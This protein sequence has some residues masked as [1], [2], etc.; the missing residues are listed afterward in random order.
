MSF[1]QIDSF[2]AFLGVGC[3]PFV[4]LWLRLSFMSKVKFYYY[5]AMILLVCVLHA[6]INTDVSFF[7]DQKVKKKGNNG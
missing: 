1:R 5:D 4:F 2:C 3:V 6:Q 7:S